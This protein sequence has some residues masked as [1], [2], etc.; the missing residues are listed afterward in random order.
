MPLQEGYRDI[1][2]FKEEVDK[3]K[4][5]KNAVIIAHYYQRP[6]IQEVADFIGDSLELARICMNVDADIIVFCGV[7]FMAE[8]AKILN[9]SKKV[10]IPYRKAGCLLSD[11]VDESELERVKDDGY[12]I[13]SY[14]NTSANV[15]AVSDVIC[16]SRNADYVVSKVN[17]DRILFIPD[18]NLA[19]YCME[20]VKDKEIVPWSG[21]CPVHNRI[22]P[23]S[24]MRVKR[25][26]Q[27]A[28]IALHPECPQESRKIADFVGSTSQ[29]IDFVI[30]S[31]AK[32]YIIGTEEGILYTIR[33]K[34]GE[35]GMD[36]KLIMP[37]PVPYC[38]QMK[39]ITPERLVRSL[40]E[41]I[42]EVKL[43]EDIVELAKRPIMAMFSL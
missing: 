10:L 29:I 36:K 24:I 35:M 34:L 8:I 14:V 43:D 15:K 28:L 30:N 22:T 39:M 12:F 40:K 27:D 33:R 21:Y 23:E 17:S 20:K 18:Y 13:V 1:E 16:T 31:D 25:I 2:V 42:F 26:Y 9:P 37:D 5:E 4:K 19:T 32:T 3:L 38:D 11:S 7:Y 41:E 6:E